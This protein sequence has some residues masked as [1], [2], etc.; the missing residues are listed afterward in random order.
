VIA[1]LAHAAKS[2]TAA[3]SASLFGGL[4][5]FVFGTNGTGKKKEKK[6]QTAEATEATE[7]LAEMML[8]NGSKGNYN[9]DV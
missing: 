8:G 7:E 4:L 1:E 5:A 9:I 2:I 3:K 6:P